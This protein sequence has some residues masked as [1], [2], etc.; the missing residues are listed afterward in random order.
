MK[1]S[2]I[3]ISA[4]LVPIDYLMVV[5]AGII[6]FY[7]R[8]WE[9]VQEIRPVIFDLRF[10]SYLRIVLMVALLWLVSF[11]FAGLYSMRGTRRAIDEF[12]KIIL[13]CSTAVMLLMF[14][15]F[16]S[17]SLF[18]S[19]FIIIAGWL[20]SIVL[21]VAGR[22][23]VRF[24][25]HFLY[26]YGWGVHRLIIIGQGQLAQEAAAN[27]QQD[28]KSGY[29]VVETFPDF[30]KNTEA[31]LT[32]LVE[33]DKFDEILVVTAQLSS[34][35]INRLNDFSYINHI[36][37]KFVAD[38]FDW[39]ITNFEINTIAGLPIVEVKKTRL[40]GWGRVYKRLFDIIVALLLII[41]L[42]PIFILTAVA[43]K[44]DSVGPLFFSYQRIG[45]LGR[46]FKYFKFRSMVKDAHKYRFD[47]NFLNHQK[48][49][50]AGTPMMKFEKDPR[51][52]RVGRFI[53]RFSIDELPE[54]F[55]VLVGKMSLVGP[56]PHEVEEVAKYQNHHRKVLTIRPGI[57]GMAQVSGRSDL[58]FEEEIR[59]DTWYMENWS[60]KLDLMILFKTPVAIL[61]RRQAE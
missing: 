25:Q 35:E 58:D 9:P 53:R 39:P 42:S 55:N 30:Q 5:L 60:P 2:E 45:A 24:V 44:L 43:I 23:I 34:K 57:T 56:R 7:A 26:Y 20:F 11:A 16:F 47:E 32:Q 19:R 12:Y 15:F 40:D 18:D 3:A 49:L 59:L 4:S 52:T 37:L 61:R 1:R 6:S 48:N 17:R 50:R 10:D 27:F 31:R 21:V 33:Q 22:L 29:R 41:L 46:P 38:I 8:Y 14:G 36:T 28:K 13:G 51:V 54:L